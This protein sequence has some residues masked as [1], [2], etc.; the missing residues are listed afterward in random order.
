MDTPGLNRKKSAEWFF[1]YHD[2]PEGHAEFILD[3][4]FRVPQI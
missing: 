4:C 2:A 1:G 3:K